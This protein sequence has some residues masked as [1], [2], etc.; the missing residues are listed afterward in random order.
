MNSVSVA[1]LKNKLRLM[2]TS[3]II[4]RV[5]NITTRTTPNKNQ[6]PVLIVV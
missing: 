5:I 4:I 1:L 6:F 3:L 2:V